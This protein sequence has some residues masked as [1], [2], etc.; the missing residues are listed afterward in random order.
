MRVKTLASIAAGGGG[1]GGTP[2]SALRVTR[3]GSARRAKRQG[4][5]AERSEAVPPEA[6]IGRSPN[7]KLKKVPP[8]SPGE[9]LI[10]IT[11]VSNENTRLEIGNG[12]SV[13]LHSVMASK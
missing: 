13:L 6:V 12:A 2:G 10:L 4:R 8:E 11:G 9:P 3:R 5:P 1:P 7:E